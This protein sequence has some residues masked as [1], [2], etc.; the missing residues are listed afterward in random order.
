MMKTIRLM[1]RLK[2]LREVMKLLSLVGDAAED[3]KLTIEERSAVMKQM[4]VVIKVY[5]RDS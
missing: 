5:R 3:G 2:V 4:W 1:L